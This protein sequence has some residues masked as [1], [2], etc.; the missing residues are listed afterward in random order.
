MI[1]KVIHYCWFG[2]NPLPEEYKQ[3]IESWKKYC[4]DYKI[5][6]WNESNFDLNE[7]PYVKEAY[8]SK[9]WA[10]ITDY[11]RLYALD[12]IGGIYMDT[13]VEVLKNLDEFLN[14]E[15][16]SGF[17]RENA[18]PTGIMAAEKRQK[19]IHE[20]LHQYDELHFIKDDGSLDESTNVT[21]ITNTA[22]KYGLKLN[23]KKQTVQ[24]FTFYPTDY[25]C[26]KNS[27]T[28][29]INITKNSCT[30]HHFAGSWVTDNNFRRA[31]KKYLPVWTLKGIV[32]IMDILGVK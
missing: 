17:E 32:K 13:D 19:F 23:N 11:V 31:V 10:F 18:V 26:P 4:P 2:G 28:M 25:F 7:V 20:L 5:I 30:I 3:Y 27:R 15:G 29:E 12:T 1:P 24:G 16:F 21:R 6:E 22:V 9:K 8:Q 14:Q